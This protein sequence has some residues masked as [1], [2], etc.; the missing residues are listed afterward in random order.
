MARILV[1]DGDERARILYCEDLKQDGH[2]V[3]AVADPETAREAIRRQMPDLVVLEVGPPSGGGLGV[4]GD[5]LSLG[6]TIRIVLHTA[7]M[8]YKD[9][10]RSWLADAYIRKTGDTAELRKAVREVLSK[11]RPPAANK[12]VR[13]LTPTAA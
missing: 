9:D 8:L 2:T 12:A 5:V 6:R 13:S 3:I 4:V 1:M 10:F 7:C 11:N